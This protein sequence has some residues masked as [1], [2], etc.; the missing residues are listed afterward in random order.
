M[1]MNGWDIEQG[2]FLNPRIAPLAKHVVRLRP[3]C[4]PLY[5]HIISRFAFLL[6]PTH[7]ISELCILVNIHTSKQNTE[8]C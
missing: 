7:N 6:P 3:R 4:L 5:V 2:E 8:I 1:C